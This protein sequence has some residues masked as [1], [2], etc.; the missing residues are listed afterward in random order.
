MSRHIRCSLSV[1]LCVCVETVGTACP[2]T[3]YSHFKHFSLTA[4]PFCE[5]L[6]FCA[7]FKL[8]HQVNTFTYSKLP[9]NIIFL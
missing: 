8:K 1:C 9:I 6:E 4:A 7:Q 5:H 3:P 2:D